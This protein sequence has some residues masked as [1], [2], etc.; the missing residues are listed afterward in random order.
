MSDYFS[1]TPLQ[2]FT[3]ARSGD[4]NAAFAGVETAFGLLPGAAALR[5]VA[6]PAVAAAGS[7]NT[8][9][10]VNADPINAYQLGQRIAFKAQSANTGPTSVNVDGVGV[11]SVIRQD[12][13]A[14]AA[15]DIQAGRVYEAVYDGAQFQILSGI[16]DLTAGGISEYISTLNDYVSSASASASTASSASGIAVGAKTDAEAARDA[17]EAAAAALTSLGLLAS[18]KTVDGT[19]SGLD[20]DLVRGAAAGDGGLAVLAGSDLAAVKATL[21]I[22]GV[23][24]ADAT[25]TGPVK[26][27]DGTA[28]LPAISNTGDTNCGIYFSAADEVSI[29]ANGVQRFVVGNTLAEV[30]TSLRV[31]DAGGVTLQIG[32]ANTGIGLTAGMNF[33]V[34]GQNRLYLDSTRPVFAVYDVINLPNA[35]TPASATATGTTGDF[36]WNSTH[37]FVCIA[38]NTWR[39]IAHATW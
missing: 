24:A 7:A 12:G 4:V 10:V 2:P 39:R 19:G 11:K 15:G 5:A 27:P 22:S 16:M 37:F 36:C 23:T 18:I 32:A 33:W 13:M 31:A 26:F 6:K 28:A 34:N 21:G 30:K 3:T 35:K 9:I 29:A 20:A 14:L 8:L 1:Y 17:A 25:F 38:T